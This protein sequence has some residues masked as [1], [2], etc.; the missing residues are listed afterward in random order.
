MTP[1]A[2]A[3]PAV[4]PT[5]GA[6]R[7]IFIYDAS[8]PPT[9]VASVIEGRSQT[10]EELYFTAIVTCPSPCKDADF[11]E[12]TVTYLTGSSWAGERT[13]DGT[14]TSWGCRLGSVQSASANLKE[15]ECYVA[16]AKDGET[17]NHSGTSTSVDNCFVEH[18][19]KMMIV[20]AGFD[21]Y[22]SAMPDSTHDIDE[23]MAAW[24]SYL[25]GLSCPATA[26]ATPTPTPTAAA[27]TGGAVKTSGVTADKTESS[28]STSPT[29]SDAPPNAGSAVY[30]NMALLFG[31][32]ALAAIIQL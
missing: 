28:Q 20:T 23:E 12:Q 10:F 26:T 27:S 2:T 3:H 25:S 21:E 9:V 15:G 11:P 31:A 4:T 5:S 32:T 29:G 13:V 24:T 14:T 7:Q 17:I 18:R 19:S 8:A 30:R 22:F 6:F 16:T 1:S